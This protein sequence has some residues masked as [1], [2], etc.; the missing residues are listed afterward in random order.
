[1]T[2]NMTG[3][4]VSDISNED[5]SK[6]AYIVKTKKHLNRLNHLLGLTELCYPALYVSMAGIFHPVPLY[7]KEEYIAI[8][9]RI[10]KI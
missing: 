10:V 3:M 1:M 9:Y 7:R 2:K 4:V 6:S 5:E 8:G